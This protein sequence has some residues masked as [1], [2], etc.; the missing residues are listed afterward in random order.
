MCFTA[1]AKINITDFDDIKPVIISAVIM[2]N[3]TLNII[4]IALIVKYPQLRE[5]RATLFMYNDAHQCRR[6]FEGTAKCSQHASIP[7]Y[8]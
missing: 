4:V 8:D 5:N 7:S 6:V 1:Q 2:L 3:I